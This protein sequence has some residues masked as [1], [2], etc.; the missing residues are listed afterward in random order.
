[1]K[2]TKKTKSYVNY[3]RYYI[4]RRNLLLHYQARAINYIIRQ[5]VLHYH[6]SSLLHYRVVL[7]HYQAVVTLS[8]VLLHY[9][10]TII[11]SVVTHTH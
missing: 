11:L 6:T 8:G 10:A 1:M 5:K 7:V 4:I 9:Q 2:S 3:V